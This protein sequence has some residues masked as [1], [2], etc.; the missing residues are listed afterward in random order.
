MPP[1]LIH[2]TFLAMAALLGG[3]AS[4][5]A[6]DDMGKDKGEPYAISA[7]AA[8][9]NTCCPVDGKSIDPTKCTM[10][11]ITIGEGAMAKHRSMAMCS[12]VC[13]SEL[14]KDPVKVMGAQI[15]KDAD[16]HKTLSK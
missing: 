10:V 9:I 1:F 5:T 2:P 11:P 3:A 13:A 8:V 7:S 4:L 15:A 12:E 16:G 14:T 6:V